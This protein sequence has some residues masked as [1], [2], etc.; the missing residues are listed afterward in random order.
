MVSFLGFNLAEKTSAQPPQRGGQ[1]QQE[2]NSVK[3]TPVEDER[4]ENTVQVK[5]QEA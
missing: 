5:W 4:E 1:A 3:A 2:S